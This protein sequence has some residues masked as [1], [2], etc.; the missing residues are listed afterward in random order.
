MKSPDG[1]D[2]LAALSLANLSFIALW[3]GLLN[4][5]PSQAFFMETPPAPPQ[6]AAAFANVI[7]LGLLFFALIRLAR[8]IAAR[9]GATGFFLGSL[10]ILLLVVLPAAKSTVRLLMDRLPDWNVPLIVG[11]TALV[12]IVSAAVFRQ[13]FFTFASAALVTISPLILIEAILSIPHFRA[14]NLPGFA[15]APL[16]PRLPTS[17]PRI[18]WIVFDEL[19]YRL[20]FPDRPSNVPM[21]EFDRLRRE[22]LFAEQAFSPAPDTVP[23]V[24][25]LITGKVLPNDPSLEAE[26]LHDQTV[27]ASAHAAGANVA[28]VGWHLPYCRLFAQDLA[29]CSSHNLENELSETGTSFARSLTVELESLVAY[30]YR[31]LLGE[32]PRVKFRLQTLQSMHADAVRNVADP[33][34]NLVYLHLPVPHAPYLYDRFSKRYSGASTYLDNLAL[35]DIYLGDLR[36]AMTAAGLWDKTAVLV[37]SDHP[38]RMSMSVD[39][40]ADPR[41]PFLLKMPSQT[42]GSIYHPE[43]RTVVTKPLLEAILS[44]KITTPDEAK[45]WLN[46]ISSSPSAR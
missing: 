10:P 5:T 41:V 30:G 1:Q 42:S 22:S 34:L 14:A 32:S 33:S 2:L 28:I 37:S 24:P 17:P 40:K 23:S 3:D 4:Y 39:G 6:Y 26:L 46:A 12:V 45:I 19:D 27:F 43:L 8:W 20:A 13:R 29:A 18:V 21:P 38:N 35:A 25:S 44:R 16:A 11:V 7:L 31:S 15:R 36:E 9:Y